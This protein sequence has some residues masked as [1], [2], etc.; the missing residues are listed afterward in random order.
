MEDIE[1]MF[2]QLKN[3]RKHRAMMFAEYKIY[4]NETGDFKFDSRDA[5][6]MT[7]EQFGVSEGDVF[8]VVSEPNGDF[9]FKRQS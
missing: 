4:R 5:E 6:G 2:K 9:Y 1:K 3:P 8:E 7:M